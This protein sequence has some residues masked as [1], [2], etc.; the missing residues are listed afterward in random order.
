MGDTTSCKSVLSLRS[1]PPPATT[2]GERLDSVYQSSGSRPRPEPHFKGSDS[3]G[4]GVAQHRVD[5]SLAQAGLR[6]C[7]ASHPPPQFFTVIHRFLW[8]CIG[9]LLAQRQMQEEMTLQRTLVPHQSY[10]KCSISTCG[11][12]Y[13]LERH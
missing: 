13:Q 10:C 9:G 11:Q 1:P 5:E 7:G 12:V 3:L 8:G 4:S 6:V 2:A